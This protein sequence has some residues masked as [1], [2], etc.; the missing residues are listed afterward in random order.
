MQIKRQIYAFF[1]I[2]LSV[3]TNMVNNLH[4]FSVLSSDQLGLKLWYLPRR[5]T[6]TPAK[7]RENHINYLKIVHI[8]NTGIYCIKKCPELLIKGIIKY[9]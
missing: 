3:Q 6:Q 4:D 5:S 1:F 2:Y 7:E 9:L 8:Y